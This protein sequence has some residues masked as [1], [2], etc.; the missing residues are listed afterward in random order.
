MRAVQ[1]FVRP[2]V[3]VALHRLMETFAAKVGRNQLPGCFFGVAG[4]S[5]EPPFL[6]DRSV[7]VVST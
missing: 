5:S 7:D 1:R 4:D 6:Q 2:D 3:Q